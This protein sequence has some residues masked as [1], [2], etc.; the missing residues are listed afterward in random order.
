MFDAKIETLLEVI[1]AG[2][3]TRAAQR[4][5]LTQP[6]VSHH[7]R[8]LEQEFGIHI[9]YKDKK[10]LRLTPEGEI[11]VKYAR[12]ALAVYRNA[13]QAIEDSRICMS[14]IGVGIT[15]TVGESCV[16]QVLAEYCNQTPGVHINIVT[17]TIKNLYD[18]MR[19]YELGRSHRGRA[20]PGIRLHRSA[21]GYRLP[22]PCGVAHPP[23]GTACQRR[24]RRTAGRAV[25]HASQGSGHA[26]D[27]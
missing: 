1:S 24:H 13:R 4:L 19:S 22:V 7:M 16:P 10:E 6:A 20:V 23:A 18:M 15:H 3:Y 12:R 2:S 8:Q 26:L 14:H 21:A 5:S 11:L 25:H 17:D 27:V 9:F